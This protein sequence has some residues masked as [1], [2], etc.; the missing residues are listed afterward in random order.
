MHKPFNTYL[1]ESYWEIVSALIKIH[2]KQMIATLI[3]WMFFHICQELCSWEH[4]ILKQNYLYHVFLD[5]FLLL[6]FQENKETL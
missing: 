1:D 4:F 2:C 6:L 5:P 3:C